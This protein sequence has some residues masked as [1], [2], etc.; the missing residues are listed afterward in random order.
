VVKGHDNLR[1]L[2]VQ[3]CHHVALVMLQIVET[4]SR[5]QRLGLVIAIDF[6]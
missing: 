6:E 1:S 5:T 3:P 2:G 4:A